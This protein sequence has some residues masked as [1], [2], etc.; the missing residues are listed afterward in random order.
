[1]C[2]FL[3]DLAKHITDT[4]THT[5]QNPTRKSAK[6]THSYGDK[7]EN[8]FGFSLYSDSRMALI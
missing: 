3:L 6:D 8:D 5:T 1:M 2:G 4:D 7:I